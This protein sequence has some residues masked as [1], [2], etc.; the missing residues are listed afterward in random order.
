VDGGAIP[1]PQ[2]P[3][4]FRAFIGAESA[5]FARIIRDV[6]ITLEN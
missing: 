3:E 6:N 1:S 2:T 4:A 5:K